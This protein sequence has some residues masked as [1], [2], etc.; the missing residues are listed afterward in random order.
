MAPLI[1]VEVRAEPDC[2]L[3]VDGATV[4]ELGMRRAG[5][6]HVLRVRLRCMLRW[7]DSSGG[8]SAHYVCQWADEEGAW[9]EADGLLCAGLAR[10]I[11]VPTGFTTAREGAFF[12]VVV[13]YERVGEEGTTVN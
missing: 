2:R 6:V 9:W 8:E 13:I 11:P 12:P 10:P 7:R 1:M 4:R 3:Y 5:K